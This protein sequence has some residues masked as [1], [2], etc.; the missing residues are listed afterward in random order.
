LPFT[1]YGTYRC[2]R[3]RCSTLTFCVYR[4]R[5]VLDLSFDCY[6]PFYRTRFVPGYVRYRFVPRFTHDVLPVTTCGY[7]TTP[8]TT[9]SHL[10]SPCHVTARCRSTVCSLL[11]LYYPFA[12]ALTC[13]FVPALRLLRR[14]LGLR[15]FHRLLHYRTFSA[16]LP[17]ALP[18]PD[19]V[20]NVPDHLPF[21]FVPACGLRDALRYHTLRLPEHADLFQFAFLDLVSLRCDLPHARAC[22]STFRVIAVY[23]VLLHHARTPRL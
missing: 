9:R 2:H 7:R 12:L 20:L 8:H 5:F 15:A 13:P 4:Y 1:F 11:P 6:L 3:T 16:L 14:V 18:L 23:Y 19:Y 21:T 10:R 22:D 17:D